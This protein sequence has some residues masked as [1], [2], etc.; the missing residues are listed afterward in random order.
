MIE[1]LAGD[2]KVIGCK[3]HGR[4]LPNSIFREFIYTIHSDD[5]FSIE[6]AELSYHDFQG[7]FPK[8]DSGKIKFG[9]CAKDI[10]FIPDS[11]PFEAKSIEGIF[12]LDHD[13]LKA[14][15]SFPGTNRPEVF[16][17]K[18]GQVYEIWQRLK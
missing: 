18:Q 1:G 15:F 7:G 11:G 12:E 14:I 17:A 9:K 4:W 6:W 10:D 3:L 16:D 8:S 13:V 5:R 2:W